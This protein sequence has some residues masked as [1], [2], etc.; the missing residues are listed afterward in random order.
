MEDVKGPYILWRDYGY[1]G[2]K[3]TNFNSIKE[4][5]EA[6]RYESNFVITKV[7][8]YEVKEKE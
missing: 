8:E 4:A 1:E 3:P 5:L 7:C 6:P 2:W